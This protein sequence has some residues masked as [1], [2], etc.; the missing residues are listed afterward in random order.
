MYESISIAC[1]FDV[2]AHIDMSGCGEII[3]SP[4]SVTHQPNS[5]VGSNEKGSDLT[6]TFEYFPFNVA[7]HL[8][9]SL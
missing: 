9:G 2:A 5:P 7:E 1:K 6:S 3:D 4:I 8:V